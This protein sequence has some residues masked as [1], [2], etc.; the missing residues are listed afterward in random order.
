M[1]HRL[2]DRFDI[3]PM[4]IIAR[5][6]KKEDRY[7]VHDTVKADPLNI[8]RAVRNK[9]KIEIEKLLLPST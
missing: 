7:E 6:L 9:L 1:L 2:R 8:T 3:R 4:E 5:Q